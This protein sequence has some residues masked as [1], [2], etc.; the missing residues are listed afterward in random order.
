[1]KALDLDNLQSAARIEIETLRDQ[2]RKLVC[3]ALSPG[4]DLEDVDAYVDEHFNTWDAA[5]AFAVDVIL[6]QHTPPRPVESSSR[7]VLSDP[8]RR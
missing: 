4:D 5:V 7:V 2:R 8:D 6:N 1:M 3:A